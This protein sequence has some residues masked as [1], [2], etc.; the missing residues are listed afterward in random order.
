MAEMNPELKPLRPNQR[1][2]IHLMVYQGLDRNE[3]Y[4]QANNKVLTT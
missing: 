1:Q 3:A 2:F 4:A